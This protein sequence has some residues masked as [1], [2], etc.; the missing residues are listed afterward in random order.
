MLRGEWDDCRIAAERRGDGAAVKIVGA[1]HA[2]RGLLLDM[3]MAVDCA[4]QHEL[5][6]RVDLA[7]AGRQAPAERRH[8]AVLDADVAMLRVGRRDDGTVPD[9]EIVF[10][11]GLRFH[12]CVCAVKMSTVSDLDRFRK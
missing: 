11:H 1:H 5:A 12:F 9:D 6:R 8:H 10:G 3:D 7:R 4:G 2:G